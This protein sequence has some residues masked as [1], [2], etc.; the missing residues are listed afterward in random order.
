[1]NAKPVRQC[2]WIDQPGAAQVQHN[3]HAAVT[4]ASGLATAKCSTADAHLLPAAIPAIARQ[5][6]PFEVVS[7]PHPVPPTVLRCDVCNHRISKGESFWLVTSPGR[8]WVTDR[9][10]SCSNHLPAPDART[11]ETAE[12]RSAYSDAIATAAERAK[13]STDG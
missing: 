10:A 5:G 7:G 9:G 6:A 4:V 13:A 2:T 12:R 1:M 11:D 3:P 8:G